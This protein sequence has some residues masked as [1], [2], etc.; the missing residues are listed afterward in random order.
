M[1][2]PQCNASQDPDARFC[3]Q[4]GA[5]VASPRKSR[6]AYG[7]AL[8]LLPVIVLASA[9]GYYKFFLPQGIAAVVNGEEIT[10]AELDQELAGM[11][12][13][14]EAADPRARYQALNALITER[15]ILQEARKAGAE[16]SREELAAAVADLRS[17]SGLDAERFNQQ[18]ESGYG[19][20]RRFKEAVKSRMI[21]NR[22][23]TT[24]VVPRG[25]DQ[26]T[27]S[28]ARDQ[29]V[30]KTMDAAVVRVTLAEHWPG[31]G[32]G[33]AER[34]GAATP[35][36]GGCRMA[37]GAA[38]SPVQTPD[39]STKEKAAEAGLAYWRE[40][41]GNDVVAATVTD[42]GCHVQI[43]I[44]KDNKII[45]SLRYQGGSISE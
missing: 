34:S 14:P 6:S 40:K 28:Y 29:W 26:Q 11:G 16:V 25:A 45:A 43:D 23:I 36:Q 20:M 17:R 1:V 42:F 37:K 10:I 41:H 31:G 9:I 7:Y 30:R 21:I 3:T 38:A 12:N 27:A 5:P 39:A 24:Q 8:L 15:V 32:C 19:S 4:C 44:V 13:S 33:C 18:V 22:F 2:C 35:E